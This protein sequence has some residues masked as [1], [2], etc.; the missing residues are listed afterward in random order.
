MECYQLNNGLTMPV[1]GFGTALLKPDTCERSVITALEAGYRSI[2]TANLYL[3]ERAVGR[4]LRK[5]GLPR[6]DIFLTTKL[7]PPDFGYEKTAKAIDSTLQRLDT[8]YIDLLLLHWLFGDYQG[9]WKAMQEAVKRGKLKSI[10]ISNFTLKTLK[11][12][13]DGA[14]IL[15]AI[16]Q[17]ECHPYYQQQELK[18]FLQPYGTLLEAYFPLGHGDKKLI[19]EEVFTRLGQT[20][21][22]SNAQIILKWHLQSGHIII[23]RSAN[24][25][26]IRE[27]IDLFDFHLTDAE[28]NQIA[29]LEKNTR[30]FRLPEFAQ[31]LYSSRKLNYDTQK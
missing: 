15:P 20:Y 5:S 27:N 8:E 14:E 9:A 30:F 7:L 19:G 31:R 16:S 3:N 23:P 29:A 25:A 12:L 28:M 10:G 11:T 2:D 24:P 26:H 1:V 22:K 4:A 17:V 6:E 18:T 21:G 13:I